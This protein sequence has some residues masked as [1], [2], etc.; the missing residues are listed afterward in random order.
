ML[1]TEEFKVLIITDSRSA[2]IRHKLQKSLLEQYNTD[3]T[4][5]V[6]E[7]TSYDG[8]LTN[9]MN[10]AGKNKLS[11]G[12][13]AKCLI[14]KDIKVVSPWLGSTIHTTI[15]HKIHHEYQ[16]LDDG[17]HPGYDLENHWATLLAKA[18]V[19]CLG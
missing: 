2:N 1:L 13:R 9:L 16:R 14:N 19:K 18:I 3:M 6:E 4:L 12:N 17:Y 11:G 15:H 10:L 5:H 7:V 8:S